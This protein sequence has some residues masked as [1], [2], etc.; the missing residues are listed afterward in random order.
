M[1]KWLSNVD[2]ASRGKGKAITIECAI[3]FIWQP[4]SLS[5]TGSI[6]VGMLRARHSNVG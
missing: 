2:S 4:A 1:F 6:L 5:R 3:K